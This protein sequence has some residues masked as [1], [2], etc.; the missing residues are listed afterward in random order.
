MLSVF[1]K[2]LILQLIFFTKEILS[3]EKVELD[4]R[5]GQTTYWFEEGYVPY[6][7]VNKKSQVNFLLKISLIVILTFLLIVSTML[8][9]LR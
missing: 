2:A 6:I 7:Y 3:I 8:K 4:I 5:K 9:K 1:F